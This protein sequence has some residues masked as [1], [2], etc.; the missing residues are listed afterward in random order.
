MPSMMCSAST[1]AV[2]FRFSSPPS[3]PISLATYV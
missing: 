2:T 1:F 3:I